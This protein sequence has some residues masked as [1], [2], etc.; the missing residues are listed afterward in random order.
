MSDP[1][2]KSFTADGKKLLLWA[3]GLV[4]FGFGFR[5]P[6]VGASKAP[7]AQAADL[8][9]G[10][11]LMGDA[12]LYEASEAARVLKAARKLARSNPNARPGDF[13]AVAA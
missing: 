1:I 12:C 3:D 11:W 5:V 4:T 9:A 7:A 13:R 8:A 6:G 10:W 2:A